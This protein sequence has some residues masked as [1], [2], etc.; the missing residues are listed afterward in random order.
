MAEVV[1]AENEMEKGDRLN[2]PEKKT[3]NIEF[4]LQHLKRLM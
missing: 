4:K 1:E 3:L 2:K